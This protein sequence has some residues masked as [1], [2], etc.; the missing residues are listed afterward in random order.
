VNPYANF[1]L[2]M[3]K[4]DL[5]N[6]F[7]SAANSV[8]L[9]YKESIN[10][11]QRAHDNGY[12]Q[13]LEDLL[14]QGKESYTQADISQLLHSRTAV[15][16]VE[17]IHPLVELLHDSKRRMFDKSDSEDRKRFRRDDMSE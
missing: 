14:K 6:N 13:A 12:K 2:L 11:I 10:Q 5:A 8:A 1:D 17:D 9:L 3:E 15:Q 4:E 7:R 16:V